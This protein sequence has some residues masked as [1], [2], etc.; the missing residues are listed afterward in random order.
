VEKLHLIKAEIIVFLYKNVYWIFLLILG[1]G[2]RF[3][4]DLM[5]NKKLSWI[6]VIGC[7]GCGLFVGAMSWIICNKYNLRDGVIYVPLC[8]LL[9]QNIMSFV[10]LK[11]QDI[12]SKDWDKVFKELTKKK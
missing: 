4:Y 9:G 7:M 6:Y 11:W 8:T 5:Q 2:G 3:C 12:L 10:V 1:L